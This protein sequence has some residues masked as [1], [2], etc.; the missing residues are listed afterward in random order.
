MSMPI[1][2]NPEPEYK[3]VCAVYSSI[4][5]PSAWMFESILIRGASTSSEPPAPRFN[6]SPAG[7]VT[8]E[9]LY[10]CVWAKPPLVMYDTGNCNGCDTRDVPGAIVIGGT[11]VVKLTA[12]AKKSGKPAALVPSSG[13]PMIKVPPAAIASPGELSAGIVAALR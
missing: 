2:G 11:C 8:V 10:I 3:A 5:P 12:G 9:S 1:R 4:E 6:G 13:S 7:N